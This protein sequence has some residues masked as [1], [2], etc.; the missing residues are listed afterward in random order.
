[1]IIRYKGFTLLIFTYL[2][3]RNSSW[4][5]FESIKAL[6]IRTSMLFKIPIGIP[7]KEAKEEIEMHPVIVEVTISKWSI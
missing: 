6:E 3:K 5:L 7:T 2:L 4:I 1:M